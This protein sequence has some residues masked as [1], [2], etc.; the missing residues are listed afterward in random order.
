MKMVDKVSYF[1]WIEET[2]EEK[3]ASLAHRA[4]KGK[5]IKIKRNNYW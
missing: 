3:K 2:K 1:K 5:I 4:K